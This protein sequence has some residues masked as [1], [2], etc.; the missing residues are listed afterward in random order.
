MNG[1]NHYFQPVVDNS[2]ENVTP[3]INYT[4]NYTDNLA[5]I[6]NSSSSSIVIA[7]ANSGATNTYWQEEDKHV[8]SQTHT[9]NGPHVTLLD[10]KNIKINGRRISPSISTFIVRCQ[11]SFNNSKINKLVVNFA[12]SI[13]Q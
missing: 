6:N 10:G 2:N 11:K 1:C 8:S 7:K 13:S 3:Y 5:R 12:G 4:C 9:V